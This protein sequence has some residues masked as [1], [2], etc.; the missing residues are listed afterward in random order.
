MWWFSII[1]Y[2][3]TQVNDRRKYLIV[4]IIF[5]K[6][7]NI[8]I[9]FLH[10]CLSFG[11]YRIQLFKECILVKYPIKRRPVAESILKM[12]MFNVKSRN[13]QKGQKHNCA[14]SCL[15]LTCSQ[16]ALLLQPFDGLGHTCITC[17]CIRLFYVIYCLNRFVQI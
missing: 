14:I 1:R 4:V 11:F 13:A 12:L 15:Q 7:N 17:T 5:L 6:P 9:L 10:R 8:F 3:L 16:K 2:P